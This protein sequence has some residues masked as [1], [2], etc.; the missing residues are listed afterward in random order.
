MKEMTAQAAM[1][2]TIGSGVPSK[3]TLTI[4][5]ATAAIANC[6]VPISAEAVPAIS[7]CASS[8]STASTE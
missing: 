1:P 6:S 2:V 5:M 4:A 7:P 8:A 3:N